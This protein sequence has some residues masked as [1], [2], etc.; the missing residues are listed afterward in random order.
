M[1]PFTHVYPIQANL[2]EDELD[3]WNR[4]R[5]Y[6]ELRVSVGWTHLRQEIARH[7][8][9][10]DAIVLDCTSTDPQ[11]V[12]AFQ[13]RASE[14]RIFL[15]FIDKTIADAIESAQLLERTEL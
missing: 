8:A 12:M 14:R 6:M 13:R 10:A 4:G 15:A 1:T 9:D 7:V 11:V 2:S 5:A 3:V